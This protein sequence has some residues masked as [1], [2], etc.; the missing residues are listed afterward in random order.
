MIDA[1]EAYLRN[2]KKRQEEFVSSQAEQANAQFEETVKDVS[3]VIQENMS[4]VTH[5]LEDQAA[6]SKAEAEKLLSEGEKVYG[7]FKASEDVFFAEVRGQLRSA[8]AVANE[9]PYTAAVGGTIFAAVAFSGTRGRLYRATIGKFRSEEA[10]FRSAER[11]AGSLKSQLAQQE[12]EAVKIQEMISKAEQDYAAARA[13]VSAAT[14]QL[15][16]MVKSAEGLHS[17]AEGLRSTLRSLHSKQVY[18]LRSEVATTASAVARQQAAL[19]RRLKSLE[20]L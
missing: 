20:S 8:Y 13:K 10:I 19:E 17:E 16:S 9:N 15:K 4:T 14:S 3:H 5:T 12:A 11:T 1:I 2:L 6:V 7:G 18:K